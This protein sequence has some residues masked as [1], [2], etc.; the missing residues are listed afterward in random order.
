MREQ[1]N[2]SFPV[3]IGHSPN[4]FVNSL[5]LD[6]ALNNIAGDYIFNGNRG[7][8]IDAGF[9]YDKDETTELSASITDLGFIRW[10]KNANSFIASG[11]Y[12]FN[13]ADLALFE[14]KPGTIDLVKAI[15]DSISQAFRNSS[16][17]YYTLTPIKIFGGITSLLLPGLRAGAMAR[18]EIYD[19]HVMPSLSLSMNYTPIPLI[20]ASLS[21][22]IMN[23]KFNQ[24]G[25]GITIGNHIA[26][27]YIITDNIPLKFTKDLD[28]PLFWPYNARMVSLRFGLNLLFGCNQ[29][30]NKFRPKNR[31]D[32]CPAYW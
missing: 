10:K 17:T 16:R 1:I 29:K 28:S 22:T 9:V 4:G 5:N 21:Y 14:A 31:K 19:L 27:F 23:N 3:K 18:I 25:A 7:A 8:A 30:E 15:R 6:D 13:G 12:L 20:A 2:A 26:Q 24:V 32:L 11:D